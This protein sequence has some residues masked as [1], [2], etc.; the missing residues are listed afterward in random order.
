MAVPSIPQ[1]PVRSQ[2]PAPA[3]ASASMEIPRIPPRPKRNVER[4]ISPQRESFARSPLNDPSFK[5]NGKGHSSSKLSAQDVPARPPSVNL[6]LIGDEGNEYAHLTP[7][8]ESE[9]Q[10]APP[11]APTEQTKNV[12]GDLPLHAP[13]ASL[14]A[15]TAKTRI[16]AVTRTDSSQAAALGIGKASSETDSHYIGSNL[17]RSTS[18]EASRS[19]PASLYKQSTHEELEEHGI[20][21]IG[22]QVPMYPNAGDVQAPTPSPSTH[23]P[24]TGI[25][26]FNN[27]G[28]SAAG[29]NHSRTKSGREVF[30]GPPGS[31][32][33]HGHGL[34]AKSQFEKAWYDKHPEVLAQEV[35]GEYGP[36]ISDNRKEWALSSEELNKLVHQRAMDS[37]G[38]S[39]PPPGT[40]DEQIGFL[41]SEE[42]AS[43]MNSPRPSSAK[44][45]RP[46]SQ[47]HTESPLRKMSFP[48]HEIDAAIR[49]SGGKTT[50]S[51]GDHALES[52]VE[53]DVIHVEPPSRSASKYG[54]GGYDPPTQDLGPH[55]GNTDAEGGWFDETGRGTPILA[56]DEVSHRP[57][58]QFMQPAVDPE[59][60][61]RGSSYMHDI[62]TPPSG[63]R[64]GTHS[65]SNSIPTITHT[66]LSRFATEDRENAGTPLEDVQEYEPLFPEDEED[67]EVAS[68][69]K[70]APAVQ[71]K[72]K[73]PDV[74]AR[75]HFPSQDVWEDTPSSLMY[76]TTVDTP[77]L[78]DDS[79]PSAE[80]EPKELFESPE[81]EKARKENLSPDRE[82][83]LPDHLKPTIKKGLKSDVLAERPGMRHRFP[84]QD[85]WE[86][87]PESHMHTTTVGDT[88]E[89]QEAAKAVPEIPSRPA[90][91]TSTEAPSIPGRPKPQVPARPSKLHSRWSE[92]EVPLSK[93][94]SAGSTENQP[95]AVKSKPPVPARPAGGKIAALQANFMND[96]NKRLQVGPVAPKKEVQEEEE[97]E[98]KA[99][100]ADARKGRA[101]GPQRRKPG[102][103]PSAAASQETSA[104]SKPTVRFAISKPMTI[105]EVDESGG[106]N[107][108][109][110]SKAA[111]AADSEPA[112][113]EQ[114]LPKDISIGTTTD[115]LPESDEAPEEASSEEKATTDGSTETEPPAVKAPSKQSSTDSSVQTGQQNISVTKDT[116]TGEKEN[117]TIYLG[118]R[119]PEP[120]TVIVDGEGN[121]HVG[122]PD[123]L[124]GIEKITR[125]TG[126]L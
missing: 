88:Q 54:G 44:P 124:G 84:S 26:F 30:Q 41:A 48:Q 116:L 119:A 89:E 76:Q 79:S 112:A 115:D 126:G 49:G 75:H 36:A 91:K 22:L 83:F 82:S 9:S 28:G 56:S 25:G 31:Y 58:A 14:P 57:E 17:A 20:P 101:R 117:T 42:Y 114:E 95:S 2:M 10:F 122:S 104:M 80:H 109:T 5:H 40:P 51:H 123:S 77:Q 110:S 6:P 29:R 63:F 45:R 65:R 108:P 50:S 121:E 35:K 1:R 72:S 125:S 81:A 111:D 39:A 67:E 3:S 7:A 13:K 68:R 118:G 16:A 46:S 90:K 34:N 15:T 98:E 92:E 107:V 97:V 23:A 52:E 106:L 59:M 33:L 21:E 53:D 55:G 4:S 11:P 61:R 27:G 32:G 70:S 103:S 37:M 24:S 8:P 47:T 99:P 43:R 102:V 85:I 69:S 74:L 60:E 78:P 94:I 120:G 96:L 66:N 71:V 113:Y 12:A 73:R 100:L 19:R 38:T 62:D 86:D 105:W 93:S 87:S 64:S 18:S